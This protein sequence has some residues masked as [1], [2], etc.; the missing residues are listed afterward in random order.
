MMAATKETI[1]WRSFAFQGRG[2]IEWWGNE[3]Q[4]EFFRMYK[5]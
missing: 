5:A 3:L 1:L 2:D 4:G